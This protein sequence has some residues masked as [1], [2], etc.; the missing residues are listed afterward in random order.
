MRL[1]PILPL[2]AACALL[3]LAADARAQVPINWSTQ[4]HSFRASGAAP[5][6]VSCPPRGTI[7]QVWGTGTYTD[8]SSVCSAAVHAG[9]ISLAQGGTFVISVKP[10]QQSYSGSTRNGVATSSYGEWEGSFSLSGARPPPPE[11]TVTLLRR[12]EEPA[13]AASPRAPESN[14]IPWD[15]T[16]GRLAP[17]GKRFTFACPPHGTP[18][19]IK[20]VD[21]Y[22]WDSSICTAAV[23]AGAI[24][25]ERGGMVTV[26]MRPGARSYAGAARNGITSVDGAHTTLGFVIIKPSSNR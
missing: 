2:C 17:N 18:A 22:S 8:D 19:V 5:V 13:R 9:L 21:I 3:L 16:A 7:G 14:V 6:T 24:T 26:E 15:R 12:E 10:G 20:G 11:P 23:H 1:R 4:G 25:L